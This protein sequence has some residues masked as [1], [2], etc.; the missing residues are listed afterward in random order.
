MIIEGLV[1]SRDS[2]GCVNCA[3]MGARVVDDAAWC[4]GAA[5]ELVLRPYR[6][7]QTY[8]NLISCETAVF[9]VTDDVEM[10]TRVVLKQADVTR[11]LCTVDDVDVPILVDACRW[12]A[13]RVQAAD[14]TRQPAHVTCR[15]VRTG[16]QRAFAGLNR[17]MLAVVE[18]AILAT[19]IEYQHM[20][21]WQEQVERL[22]PLVTKTGGDREQR[23]FALLCKFFQDRV[24]TGE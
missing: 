8:R 6:E 14:T 23:A 11:C 16:R 22:A 15:V 7:S 2:A 24:G 10:L 1:T 13:L 20:T 9:H 12:Y 4:A 5:T 18:L 21:D 17:A 3:A 19:R